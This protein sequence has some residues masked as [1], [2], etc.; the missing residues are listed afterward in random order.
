M[1]RHNFLD[2][3]HVW[4]QCLRDI[5]RSI[6]IQV[7]L[8]ECDQHTWWSNNCIIQCMCKILLAVFAFDT[9]LAGVLGQLAQD[10]DTFLPAR[11]TSY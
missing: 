3:T 11:E 1:L 8:K 2:S 5:N 7:I 10:G 6:C 9:D 4:L